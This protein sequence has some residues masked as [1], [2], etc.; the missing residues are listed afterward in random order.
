[1]KKGGG[2]LRFQDSPV[3]HATSYFPDPPHFLHTSRGCVA[4]HD[5]ASMVSLNIHM[6]HLVQLNCTA[7][8]PAG[9]SRENGL[10]SFWSFCMC[11]RSSSS[12]LRRSSLTSVSSRFGHPRLASSLHVLRLQRWRRNYLSDSFHG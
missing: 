4:C 12:S 3:P 9:C 5:Q 7:S 1:M 2:G 6:P 8:V 10:A 11:R